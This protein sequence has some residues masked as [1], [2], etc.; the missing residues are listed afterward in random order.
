MHDTAMIAGAAFFET[1][2][3]RPGLEIVEIGAMDVGNGA[4]RSAAPAHA[5]RYLGLDM[6]AGP[7]VDLVLTDP[8]SFPLPDAS[9]DLVV[10]SSCMEHDDM[11]WLTFL[12][13]ARITRPGGHIYINTPS[14]GVVH[15]YPMDCWRFYP[16]SGRGLANWAN[17]QGLPVLLLEAMTLRRKRV[18]WNDCVLVF[19]REPGPDPAL[20]ARTLADRFPD[21]LN[22]YQHG[23]EGLRNAAEPTE[24]MM[25]IRMLTQRLRALMQGAKP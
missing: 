6:A 24:D 9:T 18:F 5:A 1:Y 15:R 14:N 12:E 8:H 20:P 22:V 21:A 17:R 16:D 7:S 25:I 13:M 4:L 19:R 2:G 11:F 3:S 23:Q 10:S